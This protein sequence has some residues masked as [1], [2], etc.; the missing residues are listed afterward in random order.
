[1]TKNK[2]FK[3]SYNRI[4]EGILQQ[5]E[6]TVIIYETKAEAQK[7]A[8]QLNDGVRFKNARVKKAK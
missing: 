7:Y 1:M 5:R 4:I 8:N 2:G 6:T 3:V